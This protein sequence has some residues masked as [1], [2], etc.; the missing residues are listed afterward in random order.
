MTLLYA[1]NDKRVISA[2]DLLRSVLRDRIQ[3]HADL[4]DE[5]VPE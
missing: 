5:F 3:H 1:L 2:L 4:I